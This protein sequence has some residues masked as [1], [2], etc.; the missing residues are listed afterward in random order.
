MNAELQMN[1][2]TFHRS[3]VCWLSFFICFSAVSTLPAAEPRP[4]IVTSFFPLYCWTVNIADDRAEVENLL[5][6][7]AEPHDYAFTPNDAQRLNQ[8]DLIVVNGLGLE[9][10]V[11]K[12]LRSDPSA[13]KRLLTVS[14]G[15][16]QQPLDVKH[17]D[18]EKAHSNP[19]TWLDPQLA[20]Q[21]VSNILSAL[22][23]IDASHAAE[24]DSNAQSYVG[25][26]RKLDADIAQALSAVTNR[27]IVTYHD[28]FPYFA[29]RYGLE[30]A[31]VVEQVP[32]VN[33]TPKYLS[34]LG[35][36]MRERGIQVIFIGLNSKTRFA[37]RIAKDLKVRLVEL[38]TLES[39]PLS[40][41]A[42]EERMRQNAIILQKN[43]K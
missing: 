8:A 40:P 35:R 7:R 1:D 25:K 28:A 11:P 18:H 23:R 38:D 30:V 39:G 5:P 27:A 14:S 17:H 10:W 37:Q 24:Y 32:D 20:I 43:L 34:R 31:G 9:A 22:Q 2:A 26:L 16:G 29:R 4:R 12:F 13:E 3:H 41:S 6:L 21:G 15:F 36:T 33:P 42:Y 19:H